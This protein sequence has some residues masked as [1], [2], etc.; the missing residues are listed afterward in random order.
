MQN[1]ND[2]SYYELQGVGKKGLAFSLKDLFDEYDFDFIG[3]Q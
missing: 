1:F 2:R 3:L